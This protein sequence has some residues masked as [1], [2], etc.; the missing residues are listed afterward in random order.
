MVIIVIITIMENTPTEIPN[1][2]KEALNL[3]VL[4]E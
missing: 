3:F 1:M 4:I 2:V